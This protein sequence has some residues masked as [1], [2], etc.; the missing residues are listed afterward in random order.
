ML[1][2]LFSKRTNNIFNRILPIC[3]NPYYT[4]NVV[5]VKRNTNNTSNNFFTHR[6]FKKNSP[7]EL[8]VTSMVNKVNYKSFSTSKI[9]I[10]SKINKVETQIDNVTKKI[11]TIEL[12]LATDDFTND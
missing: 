12:Q 4:Y 9:D 10:E 8:N 7:P 1:R 11:E 3:T 6:N 5:V 2:S